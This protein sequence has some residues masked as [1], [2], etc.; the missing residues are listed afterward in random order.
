MM[1]F[2]F[3]RKRSEKASSRVRASSRKASINEDLLGV[4]LFAQLAYMAAISES[5]VGRSQLF[6]YA[7]R[8]P[9]TCGRYFKEVHFLVQHLH[10]DYAQACGV[11][12]QGIKQEEM[13]SLLLRF[14][15]SL[16]SGESEVEFLQREAHAQAETYGSRYERDVESLK[17]W[18]DAYVAM[19][20][21][22]VIV[23][24]VSVIST[25]MID[26]GIT[27]L[28]T[29]IG[30]NI[31]VT[32]LGAWLIYRVAPHEIKTHSLD[33]RSAD[34][35]R[36]RALSRVL[37]P[38]GI[39]ACGL[40]WVVWASLPWILITFSIFVVPVGL[41][42]RRD[43]HKID[44]KDA[45][46][47]AVVSA[48][49]G[50]TSAV[51]TTV[52]DALNKIDQ[53]S[54]GNLAPDIKR[55]RT[56]LTAGIEPELCWQRFVAESGSEMV[57]RTVQ[58]FWDGIKLGG[59]PERVG[60]FSS[61]Y[62]MKVALLRAKR[63]LVSSTFSWLVLPLHVALTGLLVFILQIMEIFQSTL[64]SIGDFDI[65]ETSSVISPTPFSGFS[66]DDTS[67]F[68]ALVMVVILVLTAANAFAPKAAEG[69]HNLKLL[70]NLGI[71]AA[72]SG[73]NLLLIPMLVGAVFSDL[74]VG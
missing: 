37:L 6:E 13:R 44:L 34:H 29:L 26:F 58:M 22:G 17:K 52:T 25:L 30:T 38:A 14:S 40:V 1:Y 45:D 31:G 36:A 73:A 56:R 24:I 9:Y 8:L 49:G 7:A 32:I 3:W 11:V 51:G 42:M 67:I 74:T 21:A 65:T 18:T 41:L 72:I 70:Y 61:L 59:E 10:Y 15:G 27:F 43:D 53:R 2:K 35:A 5:G 12:G 28:M 63:G 16:S 71:M 47:P 69:G 19:V 68:V 54:M 33:I 20:V 66:P 23:V 64:A 4:D 55:L 46:I 57:H 50:V 48:L 39:V 62:S 60:R